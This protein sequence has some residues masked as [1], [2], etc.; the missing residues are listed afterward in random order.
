MSSGLKNWL[1]L[2]VTLHFHGLQRTRHYFYAKPHCW[3][4]WADHNGLTILFLVLA[5]N[6][7][8]SAYSLRFP[9]KFVQNFNQVVL[10]M[11]L[12]LPFR[13]KPFCFAFLYRPLN[14]FGI[15]FSEVTRILLNQTPLGGFVSRLACQLAWR[16]ADIGST[17]P[18]VRCSPSS[19]QHVTG[20]SPRPDYPFDWLL[21]LFRN[22]HKLGEAA[23]LTY[24]HGIPMNTQPILGWNP[25]RRSLLVVLRCTEKRTTLSSQERGVIQLNLDPWTLFAHFRTTPERLLCP[26][27]KIYSGDLVQPDGRT[28]KS[29][30]WQAR[31][32]LAVS[33]LWTRD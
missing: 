17:A 8:R 20:T 15:C 9:G 28:I 25:W 21:V 23:L 12:V 26:L 3:N 1:G 32:E 16:Y 30:V 2:V 24:A 7:K 6:D 11:W 14:T 33:I 29:M 19:A 31:L 5:T 13:G 22:A 18:W 10:F 27:R 4:Y